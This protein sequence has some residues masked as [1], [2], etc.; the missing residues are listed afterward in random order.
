MCLS[1]LYHNN[2]QNSPTEMCQQGQGR[3]G[4]LNGI[5]NDRDMT[6]VIG[7]SLLLQ[8]PHKLDEILT[9]Y[10]YSHVVKMTLQ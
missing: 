2:I 3:P 1:V 6:T 8:T 5:Q 10:Q 7:K 9:E 4:L